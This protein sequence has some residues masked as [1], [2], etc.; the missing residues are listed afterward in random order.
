MGFRDGIVLVSSVDLKYTDE[1][2][3]AN[4]LDPNLFQEAFA[5]IDLR[6]ALGSRG[7]TWNL[8]LLARN[9]TNQLTSTIPSP[10]PTVCSA[11]SVVLHFGANCVSLPDRSWVQGPGP[12][13]AAIWLRSA[14]PWPGPGTIPSCRTHEP[15][16]H[17]RTVAGTSWSS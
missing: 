9:L 1:F 13:K 5:K 7:R 6:V 2:A 15:T 17:S 10:N 16:R 14:L 8:A 12:G 4:D 11:V 3:L